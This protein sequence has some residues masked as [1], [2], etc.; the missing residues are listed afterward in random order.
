VRGI[1]TD[2]AH[3]YVGAIQLRGLRQVGGAG[4]LSHDDALGTIAQQ[5][6]QTD[7]RERV[8]GDDQD[9]RVHIKIS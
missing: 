1:R 2:I 6:R 3:R 8:G 7:A 4:N 9:T 5:G